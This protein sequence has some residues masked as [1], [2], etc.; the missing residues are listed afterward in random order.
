MPNR[1]CSF[2]TV[3]FDPISNLTLIFMREWEDLTLSE[4]ELHTGSVIREESSVSTEEEGDP[5]E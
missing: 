4:E 5:F 3:S 1:Q 2:S